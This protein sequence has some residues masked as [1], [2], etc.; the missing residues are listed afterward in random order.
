MEE[1]VGME[2]YHLGF[3]KITILQH[4]IAEIVISEGV[5]IN[6]AMVKEFHQA[7]LTHLTPPFSLLMNKVHSYAYSFDAQIA[8]S[9]L[10]DINALAVVTY[11]KAA[12]STTQYLAEFPRKTCWHLSIFSNKADALTWLLDIQLS[13]VT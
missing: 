6:A 7:L 12:T 9:N 5:E 10:T 2:S 11:N 3:A 13:R 8:L 4:D 1:Y